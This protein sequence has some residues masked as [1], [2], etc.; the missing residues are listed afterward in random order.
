MRPCEKCGLTSSRRVA[1]ARDVDLDGTRRERPHR[2]DVRALP[3]ASFAA[4]LDDRD[5]LEVGALRAEP[6]EDEPFRIGAGTYIPSYRCR[7]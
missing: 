5:A 6:V 2:I 7:V 4:D 3:D 1:A